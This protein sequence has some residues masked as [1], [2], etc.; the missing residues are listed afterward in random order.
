[1]KKISL[2]VFI[3]FISSPSPLLKSFLSYFLV[4]P[5]ASDFCSLFVPFLRKWTFSTQSSF[6]CPQH[7]IGL[8]YGRLIWST[9]NPVYKSIF[10]GYSNSD[11]PL[12]LGNWRPHPPEKK[13]VFIFGD[14][15]QMW[16]CGVADSQTRSKP[17]KK[18]QITPKIAF[19]DPN[20]TFRF[21]KSHKN[22]GVGG[23]VNRF[24]KGLPKKRNFFGSFPKQ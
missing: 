17:L 12:T 20:F 5:R 18:K 4:F 15:S 11:P 1:M 21:P 22:P 13:N 23:L 7:G 16:V 19:F 14:F 24:G 9:F 10:Q 6:I 8:N 3:C 2:K